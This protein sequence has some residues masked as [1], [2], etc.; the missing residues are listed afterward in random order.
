MMGSMM[1]E[2]LGGGRGRR[3]AK[4][5]QHP[6]RAVDE[7]DEWETEEDEDEDEVG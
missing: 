4:P 7:D 3:Q 1:D 5:P 6:A 2:M